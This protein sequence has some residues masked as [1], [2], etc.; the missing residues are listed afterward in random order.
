METKISW[1]YP[2]PR[3][4]LAGAL[5]RFIGPGATPAELWLE[6]GSAIAFGAAVLAY[7]LWKSPGWSLLQTLVAAILAADMAGGIVTNATS[8]AKRWYH[9]AGQGS[10]QH[11]AFVSL[12]VL[13]ILL[14]AWLFRGMDWAFLGV[15]SACLLGATLIIVRTPVYLQRPVA[16]G[17][18]AAALAVSFYAF[19]PTRGLEWFIPFLFL[20]LLVSHLVRE[21]P[22]RPAAEA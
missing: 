8:T 5:D 9:R 22:Y 18:F 1:T 17:L 12:H 20:K 16:L 7:G 3:P 14:V 21:E 10:R 2:A 4:G 13:H 19:S 11:F 6:L 15:M